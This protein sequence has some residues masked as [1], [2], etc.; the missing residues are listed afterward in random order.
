MG[1][2]SGAVR[3]LN[4]I[5]SQVYAFVVLLVGVFLLIKGFD[6]GRELIVGAFA[7]LRTTGSSNVEHLDVA[8]ANVKVAG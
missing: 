3:A 2:V 8:Q 5:S 4:S 1:F 6:F 7:L